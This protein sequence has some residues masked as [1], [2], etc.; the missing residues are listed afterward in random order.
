LR[1]ESIEK[2]LI[3]AYI[4][5]MSAPS[6]AIANEFIRRAGLHARNLTHMQLQKLVYI[7][8]GWNLAINGTPLTEDMPQAWDYGPVYKDLYDA[9]RRFG[10]GPVIG[11][12]RAGDFGIGMFIT[13]PA[14]ANEP[15]RAALSDKERAVIDRVFADYGK[16]HA[17]QLSALTHQDGTPWDEVYNGE[18][19]MSPIDNLR[20]KRHFI[21]LA[22]RPRQS[23]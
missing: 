8:H 21:D 20:V 5:K 3:L 22:N 11:E 10:S 19:R 15:V 6:P 17:F 9:L 18:G 16:F 4:L 13:D 14:E 12:I 7:A 23:A 1:A 2:C